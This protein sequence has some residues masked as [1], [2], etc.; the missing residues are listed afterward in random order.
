MDFHMIFVIQDISL[1]S[2]NCELPL[3]TN[4]RVFCSLNVLRY[5]MQVELGP[6]YDDAQYSP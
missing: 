5:V 2:C 3:N 1:L 6:V 4:L